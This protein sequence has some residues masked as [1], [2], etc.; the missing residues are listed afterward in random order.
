MA[1]DHAAERPREDQK[2]FTGRIVVSSP[3]LD[4]VRR[5]IFAGYGIG[6]LPDHTVREDLLQRR[7][8]RLPPDDGLV[9]VEIFLPWHR[10]RT[11]NAAGRAFVDGFQR[12]TQRYSFEERLAPRA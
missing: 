10:D 6:R 9:D 2:G 5:L 12:T 4:E 8:R 1:E 11:M 3:G 7:L